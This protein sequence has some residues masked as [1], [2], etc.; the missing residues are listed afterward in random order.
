MSNDKKHL[1]EAMNLFNTKPAPYSVED[2]RR[3]TLEQLYRLRR[4]RL[5]REAAKPARRYQTKRRQTFASH[6]PPIQTGEN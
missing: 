1:V 6:L 2:E 3:A 5:Q 4:E